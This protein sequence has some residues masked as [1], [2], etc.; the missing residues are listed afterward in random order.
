MKQIL[1]ITCVA[2]FAFILFSCSDSAMQRKISGKPG[3]LIVVVPKETWD[4]EVGEAMKKVLMQPQI[5]LP[6]GEPLF[7]TID[8]PPAAFK[9]IFKT[10]RNIINVRI[11]PTLDSAKVEFKKDVWAWP[12]AVINIDAT[13]ADECIDLFN[14]NAEKVLS[15]LL[16]AERERLQLNYA[17]NI[18]KAIKN[19]IQKKFNISLNIPVGFNIAVDR[20]NFIWLRYDT[21]EITQSISIYTFPYKSDSTFTANFLLNKR[22]S[23]AKANIEGSLPGSYMTTESRVS[24]S[25]SILKVKNNYSAEMRGLW[26]MEKDFMGG[27]FINL[28]VLDVFNNRVIVLD[29]FV[30]APRFDKRN[31]LRQVE[32]MIYSLELPN[33][34][35]NDKINSQLQMGN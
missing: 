19:T 15:F 25:F 21:P 29:G 31:Y 24:P 20:E 8:I 4:G 11:S 6:Q 23:V 27:P 5:G 16:K 7:T 34:K 10:T 17:K 2:V 22:D 13:T 14:Q 32:A 18:D 30:Y 9:D 33:Q 35:E 28:S 26:K 1:S 12:Q 3:E